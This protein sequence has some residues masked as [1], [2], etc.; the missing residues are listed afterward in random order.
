MWSLLRARLACV[1]RF[2]ANGGPTSGSALFVSHPLKQDVKIKGTRKDKQM[3]SNTV[4][5]MAHRGIRRTIQFALLESIKFSERN[6][7][8]TT[9]Q[10]SSPLLRK[11]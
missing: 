5:V 11:S 8:P 6:C 4:R 9:T 2:I 3:A 7:P 1:A 10:H